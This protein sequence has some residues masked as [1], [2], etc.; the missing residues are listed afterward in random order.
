MIIKEFCAENFTAIPQAIRAGARRIE[1]CDNLTAGG[2]TVSA[3]VMEETITYCHE[4]DVAVMTIIRPRG[5]DFVYND[6]ELKIME[7][8]LQEAKRLAADGIVIGCL[9]D[10][11]WLDEEAMEHFI[12]LAQGLEIT[13]HMAFDQLTAA[14]QFKAIDWLAQRGVSRIL[15][16]GGPS[17]EPIE[18]HFPHLQALIAHANQRLTILPGGGV[19]FENAENVATELNVKEVHGTKIVPY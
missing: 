11:N 12:D 6:T 19:S 18:N 10:D 7:T 15:T 5:G 13:F 4:H 8:D 17:N 2:T 14:N 1:L 3:G 9:T 16:H